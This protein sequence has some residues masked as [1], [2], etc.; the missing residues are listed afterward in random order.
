MVEQ[1]WDRLDEE[2][3]REGA[4]LAWMEDLE[5]ERCGALR[6]EF[7]MDPKVPTLKQSELLD[8]IHPLG[9]GHPIGE[10]YSMEDACRKLGI[11]HSNG[12]RRLRS[13]KNRCPNLFAEYS[14][15]PSKRELEVFK[16]MSPK[17]GNKSV[18]D[19]AIVLGLLEDSV[20]KTVRD[21]KTSHPWI[22][23]CTWTS[24]EPEA[25]D[26]YIIDENEIRRVF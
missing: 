15:W 23:I 14:R 13:L 2:A 26:F 24:S 18:L 19:T 9:K 12:W 22:D 25:E 16:L 21:L 17:Y 6:E 11:H 20:R 4:A 8:L 5:P 7:P 3:A 10:P 1:S